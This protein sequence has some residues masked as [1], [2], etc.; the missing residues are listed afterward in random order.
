MKRAYDP[1]GIYIKA[2]FGLNWQLIKSKRG[3]KP[4]D[5]EVLEDFY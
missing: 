5:V 3:F 2:G 4:L 1:S